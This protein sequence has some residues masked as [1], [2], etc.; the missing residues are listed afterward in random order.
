MCILYCSW[1]AVANT[2]VSTN[3]FGWT[4][5]TSHATIA[6]SVALAC[7]LYVCHMICCTPRA[8]YGQ[9][10]PA[11]SAVSVRGW[12]LNKGTA[13]LLCV[14]CWLG[15]STVW[16][17][18]LQCAMYKSLCLPGQNNSTLLLHAPC[19]HVHVHALF[20]I[21]VIHVYACH[22]AVD[23]LQHHGMQGCF[24]PLRQQRCILAALLLAL[25]VSCVQLVL[26]VL[27]CLV[28]PRCC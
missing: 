3:S 13:N 8:L 12:R 16:F 4:L 17:A 9:H 2:M 7:P 28:L 15:L 25:K 6:D 22:A 21:N 11:D 5:W 1:C 27:P 10:N 24:H 18:S 19:M 20:M 26:A 23:P 14:S